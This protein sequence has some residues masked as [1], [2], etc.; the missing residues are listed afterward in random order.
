MPSFGRFKILPA[1]GLAL[2][3]WG[4]QGQH[5]RSEVV[6]IEGLKQEILERLRPLNP[7][8]VVL[9]GSYAH[10]N[11]TEDSGIAQEFSG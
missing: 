5:W 8:L 6:D 4:Q 9:F 2:V 10:G 11:P 7:E 1:S 3:A